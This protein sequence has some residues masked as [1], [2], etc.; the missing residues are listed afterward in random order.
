MA[1]SSDTIVRNYVNQ[2]TGDAMSGLV[3]YGASHK[4]FAHTPEICYPAAGYQLFLGP[5][6]REIPAG[7]VPGL[8]V[9]MRYR[10]AIYT[11]KVG[12]IGIYEETYPYLP[13]Q[14]GLGPGAPSP[15]EIIPLSSRHV[16]DSCPPHHE[17]ERRGD[18][19]R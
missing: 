2:K 12:G 13:G 9:P 18:T 5:I 17:P 19:E 4:V 11:K 7:F 1:G 14:P 15:L 3:L 8:K 16:P 10:W 6:D